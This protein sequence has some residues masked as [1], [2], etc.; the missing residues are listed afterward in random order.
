MG[1]SST[2]TFLDAMDLIVVSMEPLYILCSH[3]MGPIS[4]ELHEK[5]TQL[6]SYDS[7][8]INSILQTTTVRCVS[9]F[10]RLV[11]ML[12]YHMISCMN[13]GSSQYVENTD[14]LNVG[15]ESISNNNII[16]TMDSDGYEH[17]VLSSA[18]PSVVDVMERFFSAVIKVINQL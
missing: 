16:Y 13:S 5:N 12:G 3:L 18:S 6:Q 9:V 15:D 1:S 11:V 10:Q 8:E 4:L 7:G 14:E 17:A 2:E